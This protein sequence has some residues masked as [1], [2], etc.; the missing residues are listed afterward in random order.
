MSARSFLPLEAAATHKPA[1]CQN[2][3]GEKAI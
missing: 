1:V 2:A 3:G